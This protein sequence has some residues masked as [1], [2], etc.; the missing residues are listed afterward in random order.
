[1]LRDAQCAGETF[2]AAQ[3]Q[4]EPDCSHLRLIWPRLKIGRVVAPVGVGQCAGCTIDRLGEFRVH[5]Q[6]QASAGQVRQGR[7]QLFF[8]HHCE[9]IDAG[10]DQKHLKPRTPADASASMSSWLSWMTPPPRCPI[11]ATFSASSRTLGFQSSDGC[12]RPMS[13]RVPPPSPTSTR[14]TR[15]RAFRRSIGP[16]EDRDALRDINRRSRIGCREPRR[17]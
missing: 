17:P 3:R 11:D 4:H 2:F 14:A 16:R 15:V 8:R 13:R 9:T 7:T 5:Q 10:V 1:M 12:G 6:R